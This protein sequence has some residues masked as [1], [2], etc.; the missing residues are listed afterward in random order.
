M[1]D[2]FS[3][4]LVKHTRFSFKQYSSQTP[5][6]ANGRRADRELSVAITVTVTADGG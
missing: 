2:R 4:S 6:Q 1:T 3:E 5:K